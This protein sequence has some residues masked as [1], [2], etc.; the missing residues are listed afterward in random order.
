GRGACGI[1][2]RADGGWTVATAEGPI[3]ADR[4][5]LAVPAAA[6]ARLVAAFAPEAAGALDATPHPPL[7]VLHLS[8]PGAALRRP[9]AGL[10][11]RAAGFGHLACPPPDRRILGAVW[12][13]SL[14]PGRAPAGRA[15]LTVFLGGARDPA[16]LAHGDAELAALAARDLAAEGLVRGDPEL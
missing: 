6:A 7:A 14:F 16:V 10:G 13:P 2:P 12:S 4:V 3:A 11:P 1:E 5:L 15:L 8:W 9:P